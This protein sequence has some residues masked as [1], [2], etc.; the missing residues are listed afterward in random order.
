MGGAKKSTWIGGTVFLALVIVAAAYLLAISP[1]LTRASE[2]R[3]ETESTRQQNEILQMKVTKLASDFAKLDVYKDE[4]ATLR[5]QI[6]TTAEL[7][8]LLR[9]FDVVAVSH[10]VTL[11]AISPGEPQAVAEPAAPAA[12]A[13]P[14]DAATSGTEESATTSETTPSVASVLPAGFVTLPVSMTAVGTY[15]NVLSFIGDL[16]NATPRLF[17]VSGLTG[18]AQKESDAGSGRPATAVGDLEVTITGFA[19]TLLDPF[20]VPADVVDPAPA[21]PGAVAGKNPLVPVGG[22]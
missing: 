8:S 7:S 4:L 2:S 17:L 9:Q 22:E 16:Q 15:D 1:L 21:L 5:V 12:T 11:T 20:A 14:T 6:P 18:T 19:F 10:G 13:A 3:A